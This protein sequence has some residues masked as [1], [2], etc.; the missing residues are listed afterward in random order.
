MVNP[1]PHQKR[2]F[3]GLPF[4]ALALLCVP[5]LAGC[6]SLG[7]VVRTR[8]GA[9]G[10]GPRWSRVRAVRFLQAGRAVTSQVN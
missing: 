10:G 8:F 7:G 4:P 6:F 5:A 9:F 3:L 1:G 2:R